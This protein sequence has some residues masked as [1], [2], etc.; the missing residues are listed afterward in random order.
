MTNL[1]DI[2]LVKECL[3]GNKQAFGELVE[4][5]QKQLYNAAYRILNDGDVAKDVTQTVFIRAYE[6]LDTYDPKF[7]F[8]SWIYRMTVNESINTY[9]QQKRN[10][11]ID[12]VM[13]ASNEN[14]EEKMQEAQVELAIEKAVS[15][16]PIEYRMVTIFYY[17]ANLPYQEISFV[18]DIPE[19]TVKSRLY[20]AR[21]IL[22]KSLS[23]KELVGHD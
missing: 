7:K 11:D 12:E 6:K 14:P 10:V 4:K 1:E 21:Q 15:S 2:R 20:S 5:Y 17:F 8:F 9:R 23:E 22:S 13:I 19:K 3:N 18:L 16:L